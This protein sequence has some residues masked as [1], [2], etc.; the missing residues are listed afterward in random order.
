LKITVVYISRFNEEKGVHDPRNILTSNRDAQEAFDPMLVCLMPT[1]KVS[2]RDLIPFIPIIFTVFQNDVYN[3]ND[4]ALVRKNAYP[5]K[6]VLA[7]CTIEIGEGQTATLIKPD[8]RLL[9]LHASCAHGLHMSCAAKY[10]ETTLKDLEEVRVP[11][12]DGTPSIDVLL[13]AL[14]MQ[15]QIHGGATASSVAT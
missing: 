4:C 2:D 10:V 15:P 11:A 3:I 13:N 6:V 9:A 8:P 5:A 7:D 12:E 14:Q 1:Y